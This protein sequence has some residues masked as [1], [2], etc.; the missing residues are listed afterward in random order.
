MKVKAGKLKIGDVIDFGNGKTATVQGSLKNTVEI[1]ARKRRV[2]T[3]SLDVRDTNGP[4]PTAAFDQQVIFG[5]QE[6]KVI[7]EKSSLTTRTKAWFTN[8]WPFGAKAA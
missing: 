2:V 6:Y 5:D 8:L 7:V 1:P 3:L 4:R